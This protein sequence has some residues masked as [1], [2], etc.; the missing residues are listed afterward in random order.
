MGSAS[1]KA[2]Q[3]FFSFLQSSTR[4]KA[5][6]DNKTKICAKLNLSGHFRSKISQPIGCNPA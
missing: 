6:E 1:S 2:L 3:K 5:F 4:I